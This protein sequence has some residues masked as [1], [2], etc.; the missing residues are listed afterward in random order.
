ML[1]LLAVAGGGEVH[2][3]EA[4]SAAAPPAPNLAGNNWSPTGSLRTGRYGHTATLLAD[5]RVLV[6]GGY[7]LRG[8]TT[9]SAELYDPATGTWAATGAMG[10]ARSNATATLLPDGRVLVAGGY[11]GAILSSAELYDPATGT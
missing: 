3:L 4:P 5:G 11:G 6:A 2:A 8:D 1:L 7:A 10:Q 9:A